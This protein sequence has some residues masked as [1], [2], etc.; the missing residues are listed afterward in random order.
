M[1]EKNGTRAI[2]EVVARSTRLTLGRRH[3]AEILTKLNNDEIQLPKRSILHTASIKLDI[4]SSLYERKLMDLTTSIRIKM[5]DASKKGEHNI[6][7]HREISYSF[8]INFDIDDL[9]K[10]DWAAYRRERYLPFGCL[11]HGFG[12]VVQRTHNTLTKEMLE[13][14]SVQRLKKRCDESVGFVSDQGTDS[15]VHGEHV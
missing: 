12:S 14:G 13:S 6:L 1:P 4:F 7:A 15:K 5:I 8:P 10:A 11:G 3:A 2:Y 9:A